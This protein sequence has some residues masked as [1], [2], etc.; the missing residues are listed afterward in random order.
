MY[1]G[2]LRLSS[3][4]AI[5]ASIKLSPLSLWRALFRSTCGLPQCHSEDRFCQSLELIQRCFLTFLPHFNVH[6]LNQL[7]PD[8]VGT[9]YASPYML[10]LHEHGWNEEEARQEAI[11]SYSLSV[12]QV[13]FF[14]ST[15]L[16]LNRKIPKANNTKV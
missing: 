15:I 12:L 7:L 10:I 2:I 13:P 5:I 3:S 11:S 1:P 8:L 9:C 6:R 16:R 14:Y 4:R